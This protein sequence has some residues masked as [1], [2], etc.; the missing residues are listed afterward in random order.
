MRAILTGASSGIGH[1]LAHELSRRGYELALLARRADLLEQL[2]SEL[3]A[4]SVAI[5]CDVSDRAAVREAV[6]RGQQQLGGPFDLAIANAGIGI[7]THVANLDVDDAERTMRINFFGMLYLFDAVIP[8]MV[9]RRS[10]RFVGIASLAGLRGLP[11]SAIYSASKAAMQMFLESSRL[12]LAPL[13]VNITIVNPGFVATP[14]TEKNTF[15]M[16]LLMRSDKAAR[17]I[18]DGIEHGKRVIE[19]PRRL[20]TLVRLGRIIPDALYDRIILRMGPRR[21]DPAKVKR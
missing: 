1:A 21:W 10:G 11:A 7:P 20:S 2:A 19:F 13:G 8:S 5:P 12:D 4:K 16:P 14:L 17:V 3:P 15:R 6:A 18:A 9:E